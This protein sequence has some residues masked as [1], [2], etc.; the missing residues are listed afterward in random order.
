MFLVMFFSRLSPED[1]DEVGVEDAGAEAELVSAKLQFAVASNP[2]K[3]KP[4]IRND[5]NYPPI[6]T[7]AL[8]FHPLHRDI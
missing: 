4:K 6:Q 8:I 3:V 5:M 2:N 1:E 7:N